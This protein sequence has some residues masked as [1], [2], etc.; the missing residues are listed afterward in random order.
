MQKRVALLYT[1]LALLFPKLALAEELSDF[2][3]WANDIFGAIVGFYAPILLWKLPL[4]QMPLIV[5]TMLAGGVFFTFRY[6]M[7]NLRLFKHSLKVVAGKYDNK[8]DEGDVSHF[9]AL[10]AALSATVGLGNIAGVAVAIGM[11]GPGAVFWMWVTAFFGMSLKYSSCTLAVLYR[12]KDSKGKVLGGPMVY[13]PMAFKEMGKEKLG[14]VFGVVFAFFAIVGSFGGGN[15]FQSNQT[16]A[17]INSQFPNVDPL[18]V[19]ITLSF[20]AGIVLIGGI[21]R[22]GTVTSKL[23]PLMCIFYCISCILIIFSNASLV[24]AMFASIVTEAFSPDAMYGGL[25]GVLIIGITRA[26]FSSEAGLGSAAIAHAAAKTKEP[27]REGA[28]AMLEPFI[29]TIIVCTMTALTILITG[30]H[31]DPSIQGHGIQMTAAAFAS[32]S[33]FMPILLMV[34]IVV[35]AYSTVI[36]WSYYGERAT[37][38]LFGDRFGDIPSQL[39]KVIYVFVIIMGPVLTLDNVI[40]FADLMILSMAFPNIIGMIFLSKI[41]KERT[42]RYIQS[43]KTGEVPKTLD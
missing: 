9:Q 41:V 35:F 34:A 20:F 19:G 2:Q 14:K 12:T 30:A 43:I 16:Y 4:I 38:Y 37:Q 40:D 15:M 17:I 18:V 21:T 28:V 25:I 24:P 36:S 42:Q 6:G 7:V 32:L 11:G 1:A 31:L 8:E 22:I 3:V 29:D 13:L 33:D 26:S 27:V 39:Y 23:I 10:T 5:F